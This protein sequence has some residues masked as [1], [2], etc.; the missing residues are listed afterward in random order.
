MKTL[1]RRGVWPATEWL[2]QCQCISLQ[3]SPY[4]SVQ[5]L[6]L[7]GPRCLPRSPKGNNT[8]Q[9]GR[10]C[11]RHIAQTYKGTSCR[12]RST[13]Y[14]TTQSIGLAAII[15]PASAMKPAVSLNF[16]ARKLSLESLNSMMRRELVRS[17]WPNQPTNVL[18]SIQDLCN[19]LYSRAGDAKAIAHGFHRRRAEVRRGHSHHGGPKADT[20]GTGTVKRID[21]QVWMQ[22]RPS[23]PNPRSSAGKTKVKV[24]MVFQSLAPLKKGRISRSVA[25]LNYAGQSSRRWTRFVIRSLI[26]AQFLAL[27]STLFIQ[28]I[29]IIRFRLV[30]TALLSLFPYLFYLKWC[31]IRGCW[32]DTSRPYLGLI[33]HPHIAFRQLHGFMSMFIYFCRNM[34]R[35]ETCGEHV[36]KV[37]KLNRIYYTTYMQTLGL[38]GFCKR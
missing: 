8:V 34:K 5:T 1:T 24:T 38:Q 18:P 13:A 16:G 12:T 10:S 4:P 15:I 26:I 32:D 6:I 3:E 2:R 22:L 7:L 36:L 20:A 17:A 27:C 14:L 28:L 35:S 19:Q 23:A 9:T 31:I 21:A 33:L 29:L 11:K 25:L 30:S 37:H